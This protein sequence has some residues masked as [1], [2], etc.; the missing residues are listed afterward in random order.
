MIC[1]YSRFRA[2]GIYTSIYNDFRSNIFI[3]R[4]N[5]Q[6]FE[7]NLLYSILKIGRRKSHS[8]TT[9]RSNLDLCNQF[10][11]RYLNLLKSTWSWNVSSLVS[12]DIT[13]YVQSMGVCSTLVIPLR[14]YEWHWVD[15]YV[16]LVRSYECGWPLV[17]F[18]KRKNR[19]LL[20][21]IHSY[22]LR[23]KIRIVDDRLA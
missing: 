13:N 6:N 11:V 7:L 5:K 20:F 2:H 8:R 17:T 19:G 22:L 23:I 15:I 21:C 3:H 10:F 1:W 16:A 12:C 9:V 4:R 18:I 14:M